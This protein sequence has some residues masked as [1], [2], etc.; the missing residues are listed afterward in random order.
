V[1]EWSN[2]SVKR[3]E[4]RRGA[5]KEDISKEE[6]YRGILCRDADSISKDLTPGERQ[7]FETALDAVCDNGIDGAAAIKLYN[8]LVKSP[9]DR[10]AL[11]KEIPALIAARDKA[12]TAAKRNQLQK[13]TAQVHNHVA[14]MRR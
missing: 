7:F 4:S 5:Y 2:S 13:E 12:V 1:N 9:E 6:V 10:L 8:E 3:Y 14:K 11:E